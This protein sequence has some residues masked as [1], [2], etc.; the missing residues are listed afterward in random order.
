MNSN[1][2]SKT[3]GVFLVFLILF[4][5]KAGDASA[6]LTGNSSSSS[7]PLKNPS[8]ITQSHAASNMSDQGIFSSGD[9]TNSWI[10]LFSV[11]ILIG[12]AEIKIADQIA[13]NSKKQYGSLLF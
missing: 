11:L 7:E 6:A 9:K 12:L 3:R 13:Y 2:T 4:L 5:L 1:L 8:Y 10:V